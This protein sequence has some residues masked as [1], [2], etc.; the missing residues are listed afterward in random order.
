MEEA[1]LKGADVQMRPVLMAT[2]A[3][4][5]GLLPA[6]VATGIGSQAQ[7]PLARVVVGGMLTAA[8]LILLV[9]PVLYQFFASRVERRTLK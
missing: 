6:A 4:A 2:L 5:I 9:L 7:Q 1:I 3:A 8:V